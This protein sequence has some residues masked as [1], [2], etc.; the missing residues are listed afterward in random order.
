MFSC[1]SSAARLLSL[2]SY[3]ICLDGKEL[4]KLG[5][6]FIQVLDKCA[7]FV[8]IDS[9]SQVLAY[10]FSVVSIMTSVCSVTWIDLVQKNGLKDSSLDLEEMYCK[11][12]GMW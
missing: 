6:S 1:K 5:N 12:S 2:F 4:M 11:Y 3:L 7:F 8:S 10:D 9:I